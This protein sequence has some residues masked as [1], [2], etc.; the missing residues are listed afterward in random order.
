MEKIVIFGDSKFAREYYTCFKYD[1]PYEVVAFTVD[2]RYLHQKSFN[3]LPV[4]PFETIESVYPPNQYKMFIAIGYQRLNELRAERYSQAK[5]KGY[6]LANYI[7]SAAV[8]LPG[9]KLGDNCAINAN[10]VI[11]S[12][13]IIGNNVNV[14]PNTVIGHD[15]LIQDHCFIGIGTSISGL[16]TIKPYS[17]IGTG[18]VIRDNVQIGRSSIIGAGAVIL[19]NTPDK[20]VYIG[21]SADALPITSDKLTMVQEHK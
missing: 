18:A 9:L 21:K 6:Q 16:V 8:I 5:E 12:S 20:S 13:A 7:S 3:N 15:S 11:S 1:S 2:S 17:F 14:G 4:V 10:C 19:E